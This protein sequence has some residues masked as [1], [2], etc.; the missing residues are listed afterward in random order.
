MTKFILILLTAFAFT[1]FGQTDKEQEYEY[2]MKAIEEMEA[3]NSDVAL[4]LLKKLAPNDINY[5]YEMAYAHYL[6]TDY[7]AN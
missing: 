5:P 6:P 3:G 7:G 1:A 4:K 2:G